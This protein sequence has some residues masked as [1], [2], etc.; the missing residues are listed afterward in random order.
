MFILTLLLMLTSANVLAEPN[1]VS[2]Q[3]TVEGLLRGVE[4]R[5]FV[6]RIEAFSD[7]FLGVPYEAAPLGEGVGAKYDQGP[8]YRFDAFDCTTFVETVTALALSQKAHDFPQWLRRIRYMEGKNQFLS[9]NHF[10]CGDWVPNNAAWGLLTDITETLAGPLG[11]L[12]VSAIEHKS[13]WVAHLPKEIIRIPNLSTSQ[14]DQRYADL[15]REAALLSP[16]K[17]TLKYIPFE[18]LIIRKPVAEEENKRRQAE[19]IALSQE[20]RPPGA[21]KTDSVDGDFRKE[22][23]DLKLKYLIK[24]AE[25]DSRFLAEISSGTLLNMVRPNYS[26]PGSR[27]L[28]S[29]QGL[30][31]RKNGVPYFRHT[32]LSGGAKTKDVLLANYLRLCLLSPAIHGIQALRI[33]DLRR[34]S[35]TKKPKS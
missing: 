6:E 16:Q 35:A 29:H 31:I 13:S 1:L 15:Q 28:I 9:R 22:L 7:Q 30:V 14:R 34:P 4:D 5:G 11:T 8:S 33:N 27:L 2:Q 32:S 19:E 10:P 21:R 20:L 25:V 3:Y 12:E 24:D 26:V 18:K 17:V 23:L